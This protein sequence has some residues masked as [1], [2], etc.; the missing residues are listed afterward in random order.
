MEK[1]EK[2]EKG[3]KVEKGKSGKGEKKWKRGNHLMLRAEGKCRPKE[4]RVRK[5]FY[6][7]F[8][9]GGVGEICEKLG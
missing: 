2:A 3:E 4:E 9:L 6:C 7:F 1:A 8:F 5:N